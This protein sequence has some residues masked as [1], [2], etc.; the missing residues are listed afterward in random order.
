[1]HQDSSCFPNYQLLFPPMWVK[2]QLLNNDKI[3]NRDLC[4]ERNLHFKPPLPNPYQLYCCPRSW[5][6]THPDTHI[7]GAAQMMSATPST[8]A[9]KKRA[10]TK[11]NLPSVCTSL[12]LIPSHLNPTIP[13]SGN[14]IHYDPGPSFT[15]S[16]QRSIYF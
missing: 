6:S 4:P 15:C 7:A 12:L 5:V 1:M 2:C 9:E 8:V 14:E 11:K 16:K 3:T 13:A 10:V